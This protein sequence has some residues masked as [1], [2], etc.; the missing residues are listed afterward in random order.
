MCHRNRV[1]PLFA[2]LKNW[3]ENHYLGSP[4][5]EVLETV[6]GIPGNAYVITERVEGQYLSDL[7]KPWRHIRAAAGFEDVRIPDLRHT[8]ASNGVALGQGLQIIGK[9]I[10]HSQAQ[11]TAR[12][13]HLTADPALAVADQISIQI[14]AAMK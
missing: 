10:G 3:Q 4:A 12:Y 1:L 7:Q 2:G 6:P 8:F 9:L 13:A 14:A 11:T 5:L